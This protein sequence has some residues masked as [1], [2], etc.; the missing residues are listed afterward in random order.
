MNKHQIKETNLT[1]NQSLVFGVLSNAE[2]PLSAY[3]ILDIL[4]DE[5]F[6]A[7]LQV[8]RALNVLQKVGLIHR[9][10]CLNAFV[11]CSQ[12]DCG[13]HEYIAFAICEICEKVTEFSN[14][15]VKSGL[16]FWAGTQKFQLQQT[17]IELRGKC[18]TC[19]VK[20]ISRN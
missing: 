7:P 15:S 1:K 3:S 10:E 6:K 2:S 19:L 11:A 9:I 12:P 4:R 20:N 5:G 14:D 8:Y 13:S 18:Q 16:E 17:V